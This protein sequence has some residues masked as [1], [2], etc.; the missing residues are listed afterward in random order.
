MSCPNIILC[1]ADQLRASE[2]ACY[3]NPVIRT[4]HLDRLAAAGLRFGT[5]VSNFPVCMAARSVFV[6]ARHRVR[7]PRQRTPWMKPVT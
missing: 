4:L 5:A 3:G 6:A 1:C 2:V 7:S